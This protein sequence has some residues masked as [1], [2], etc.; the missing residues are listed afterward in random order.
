MNRFREYAAVLLRKALQDEVALSKLIEAPDVVDEIVGFH[1]QQ[2]IEKLPKAV[3]SARD[4][5]YR[6]THDL[7][8]LI[9]LMHDSGVPLPEQ[10][11]DVSRLTSFAAA[12][13]YE[14]PAGEAGPPLDRRWA[15][16]RV[17]QMRQWAESIVG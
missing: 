6:R 12:L 14:D 13:R 16:E 2:V 11:E 10:F 4:V 9:D 5:R 15:A 7:V 1:A 17:R 3:L 8:D